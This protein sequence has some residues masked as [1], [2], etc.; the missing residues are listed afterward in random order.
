MADYLWQATLSNLL[1]SSLLAAIAWTVQ[2]RLDAAPLANFLWVLVLIKMVTPPL[3]SMQLLE[4]PPLATAPAEAPTFVES[5]SLSSA[6]VATV[7]GASAPAAS[8]H[9]ALRHPMRDQATVEPRDANSVRPAA[10]AS[11]MALTFGLFVWAAGTMFLTLVSAYRIGRFHRMLR[12]CA[13]PATP[14]LREL[15]SQLASEFKLART[16]R[17]LQTS[18]NVSPFVW[19]LGSGA[20]IVMPT[21]ASQQLSDDDLRWIVAHEMAHIKRRDH[22]VRWLE[23]LVVLTLWWNPIM[24]WA[25]RQLRLTEEIAC[26]AVVLGRFQSR[27]HEYACSLLNVAELLTT[28]AIRPPAVASA[29]HSGGS[30]EKRLTMIIAEKTCV[31]PSWLRVTITLLALGIFPIGLVYAQDVSAVKKRLERAVEA[32]EIT[33]QQARAMLDTLLGS[34]KKADHKEA[35][36]KLDKRS[37][38]AEGRGR[39]VTGAERKDNAREL[40]ARKER[41]IDAA[42]EIERAVEAGKI[43]EKDAERELSSL[44]KKLFGGDP[45]H[46]GKENANRENAELAERKRKY[47]HAAEDIEQAVK[48]GKLS[49]EQA[50]EKLRALKSDL[51][52]DAE[53]RSPQHKSDL[54]ERKRE[55]ATVAREV[56]RALKAG[57]ITKEDAE[58]KLSIVRKELFNQP[59]RDQFAKE[60]KYRAVAQDIQDAVKSGKLSKED[61]QRKLK[62]AREDLF[63]GG[64]KQREE[65]EADARKRKFQAMVEDIEQAVRAGKMS[66]AEAKRK[67]SALHREWSGD[68]EDEEQD[69]RKRKFQAFAEDIELAVKS[70]KLSKQ[71]AQQKLNAARR[72]LFGDDENEEKKEKKG[73]EKEAKNKRAQG[74]AARDRKF[75]AI[76]EDIERAVEA[77]KLSKEEAKEKL[78]EVRRRMFGEDEKGNE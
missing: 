44:R 57:K 49:K 28:A 9:A 65:R 35:E 42:Q 43:S 2:R 10:A 37:K 32:K 62:A 33:P 64:N 23:W 70:G 40:D 12:R 1:V 13:T 27:R 50:S 58:R 16:P 47:I 3:F 68:E 8:A 20:Q 18:A 7:R 77:G 61:A 54:N 34:K 14:R 11:P 73:Y 17:V 30:L 36:N 74:D 52:G 51:F 71:D 46:A 19:S 56:E 78:K 66:R 25:R 4:V 53:G 6:G 55:Y 59:D 39:K 67:L 31:A 41:F 48:S 22:W 76:A 15:A 29:I 21:S 75:K 26:D 69:Q 72:E 38:K 5:S 60:N 45:S 63:G 24:W